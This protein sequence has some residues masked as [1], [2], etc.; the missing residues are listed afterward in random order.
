MSLERYF[1][2]D[3]KS[4]K[5]W[6]YTHRGKTLTTVSGRLGTNGRET[7][8]TFESTGAAR[9]KIVDLV[10]QK[11][12]KGYIKV[13]P[14]LLKITN[15]KGHRAATESQVSKLEQQLGAKLPDEYRHFLLTTNGGRVSLD[16]AAVEI[17]ALPGQRYR[18]IAAVEMFGTLRKSAR[19]YE[20]LQWSIENVMP[21]LPAGHLPIA[22]SGSNPITIDLI[23][24]PGC[25]YYFFHELP[26]W[27]DEDD[28][29]VVHYKM[30]HGTLMAGT[31]NE[32]LTRIAVF[33]DDEL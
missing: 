17:F 32:L 11:Q 4:R 22:D 13:D 23:K 31:F 12:R 1:F 19:F 25:I 10:T 24:K 20:G 29:G 26:G 9:E 5:F 6:S 33:E 27:E 7:K 14:T 21:I 8:H 16:D 18:H 15:P 3:G 28:D 2:D 30:H